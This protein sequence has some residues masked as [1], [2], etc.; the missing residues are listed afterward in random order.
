MTARFIY[1][2]VY[3]I[4]SGRKRGILRTVSLKIVFNNNNNNNNNLYLTWSNVLS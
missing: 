2:F 1:L 3:L 4:K